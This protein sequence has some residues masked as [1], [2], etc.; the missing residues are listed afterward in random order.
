VRMQGLSANEARQYVEDTVGSVFEDAAVDALAG[1]GIRNYLDMQEAVIRVMGRAWAE[2][3]DKVQKEDVDAVFGAA[4]AVD[5]A[6]K[7]APVA[8]PGGNDVLRDVI[9]KRQTETALGMRAAG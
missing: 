8:A 4:K 9:N 1:R 3:R 6:K 5:N 7:P 2:G